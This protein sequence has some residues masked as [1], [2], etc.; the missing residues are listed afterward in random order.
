[1][2]LIEVVAA[3][4]EKANIIIS[5]II[6][7]PKDHGTYERKI[8]EVNKEIKQY[9]KERGIKFTQTDK[10]F[11]HK[12]EP[13]WELFAKDGLHLNFR[14]TIKLTNHFKEVLMHQ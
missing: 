11:R 2:G 10:I 5:T 8:V 13:K 12:Y 1:M 7:R 14:G 4:N 9:A 3:R 6:P